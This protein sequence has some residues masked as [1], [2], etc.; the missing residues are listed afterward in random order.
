MPDEEPHEH[1]F[2]VPVWKPLPGTAPGFE[3]QNYCADYSCECGALRFGD[4]T[5]DKR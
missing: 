2:C 5:K 3:Q 4:A 1:D